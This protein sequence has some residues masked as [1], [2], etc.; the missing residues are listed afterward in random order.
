MGSKL[1]LVGFPVSTS[2]N[3]AIWASASGHL[4]GRCLVRH[5]GYEKIEKGRTLFREIE[6]GAR[7]QYVSCQIHRW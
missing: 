5:T 6:M 7:I 1:P 2:V 3:A 4:I